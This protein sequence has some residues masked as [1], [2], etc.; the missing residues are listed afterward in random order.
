[1]SILRGGR[2]GGWRKLGTAAVSLAA[3]AAL[4]PFLAGPAPAAVRAGGSV[5]VDESFTGATALAD[6]RAVG[7]AC[8]TGAQAVTGGGSGAHALGGC[9]AVRVGAVPPADAAPLGYLQLTDAGG[10]QSAAVLFNRPL[11]ANEGLQVQFE[12]WQYGST[13]PA[14]PADGISFFLVDGAS[15][16]TEPGAFGGSL[17]YAQKLPDDNAARPFLPGV[18][19]GYLGVGMDVLGNYFGDWEHR[20]HNCPA[21]ERSP[22]GTGFRVPGPGENMVTVRGPGQG[23]EGYCLLAATTTN[24]TTTAPWPSTLA[25]RLLHGPTTSA[26][27]PPGTTP[28]QAQTALEPSRRTIT[29]RLSPAP[30]PELTVLVDFHDGSGAHQV[31]TQAAPQPVPATY[32]FGF[33]ASTGGFTDVHLVRNVVAHSLEALPHLNLVKQVSAA[34]PLPDVLPAGSVVPYQFVVTNSGTTPIT[35][36]T[37]TDPH[38]TP[39]TC[40]T[41]ILAAGQTVVCT[42]TYTVTPADVAR[43]YLRNT[44]HAHGTADGTPISSPP[45]TVDLPL[46]THVTLELDKQVDDTRTYAAGDLAHYSYV[47]TNTSD[48]PADHLRIDDN[49]ITDVTCDTTTLAAHNEPGDSTLCT[50]TYRVTA[51]DTTRG[52]LDNT[53]FAT[54]NDGTVTSPPAHAR[55]RIHQPPPTP[56]PTPTPSPTSPPPPA[57]PPPPTATTPAPATSLAAPLPPAPSR[58]SAPAAGLLAATGAPVL[59][60]T[61]LAWAAALT[62]AGVLLR[63]RRANRH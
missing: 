42:G 17:G 59:V 63:R 6:F 35:D 38:V 18:D 48:Q 51:A 10:D 22:A 58:P 57:P 24:H 9:Q 46:G 23:T 43:G 54:A 12:Q 14:H 29:V 25:P 50:G 11:P 3:T 47:V 2:P 26:D 16:L 15:E 62:G 28:A 56:P 49:K 39:V 31:L 45:S 36:L 21:G 8:L 53:A 55:I 32:K 34:T 13:T 33:A 1:M 44:A 30:D 60:T 41:W 20:G 40:P 27:L 4:A 7:P 52:H 5:L 19:H 61:A 37:V